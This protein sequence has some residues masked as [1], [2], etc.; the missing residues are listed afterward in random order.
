MPSADLTHI[1]LLWAL[2][3]AGTVLP[4]IA[5][6]NDLALRLLPNWT[7]LGVLATGVAFRLLHGDLPLGLA[8]GTG[9]FLVTLFCWK[10]GW[11][12]GGDVKLLAACSLLVPPGALLSLLFVTSLVG[13]LLATIYLVLG[14]VLAVQRRHAAASPAAAPGVRAKS[15][16]LPLRIWAVER[17]RMLR[18]GP[19]PYGCAIAGAAVILMFGPSGPLGE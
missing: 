14:R 19:L 9:V 11:M 6:F 10:R 1:V 4:A 3:G 7:S 16:V 15:R 2:L 17:Q 8:A 5:A 12:G 13:G 18:R